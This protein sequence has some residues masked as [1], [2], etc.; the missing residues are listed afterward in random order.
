MTDRIIDPYGFYRL[1]VSHG[2]PIDRTTYEYHGGQID[3]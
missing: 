3:A 1:C 2:A